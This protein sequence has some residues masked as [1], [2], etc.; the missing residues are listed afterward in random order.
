[1]R[2]EELR[3]QC[4]EQ[5]PASVA[6]AVATVVEHALETV[7]CVA[8]FVPTRTGTTAR[9]IARFKPSV[10]IVAFTQDAAVRQ[11]LLFS[12]GVVPVLLH[13]EPG[14]WR[15]FARDW[16]RA[17][18]LPGDVAMLVAGPSSKFPDANHRIEFM[19]VRRGDTGTP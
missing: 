5:R 9:M 3:R 15:E 17:Q 10:W 14:D 6:E 7:P 11:G 8:A 2:L 4:F 16:L 1:M 18:A 12:Y 19:D 13:D